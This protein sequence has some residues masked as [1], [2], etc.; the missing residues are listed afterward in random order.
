MVWCCWWNCSDDHGVDSAERVYL[1]LESFEYQW[2]RRRKGR[3]R[4]LQVPSTDKS[5][6]EEEE[7]EELDPLSDNTGN[8]IRCNKVLRRFG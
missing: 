7:E 1:S 8:I 3:P 6:E 5:E 4:A 2:I